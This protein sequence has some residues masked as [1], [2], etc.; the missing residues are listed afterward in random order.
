MV[1]GAGAFADE[2]LLTAREWVFR[3]AHRNGALVSAYAYIVFGFRQPVSANGGP[4]AVVRAGETVSRNASV[5]AA[6]KD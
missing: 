3:P 5:T 1:Q 6:D 2:A 4:L